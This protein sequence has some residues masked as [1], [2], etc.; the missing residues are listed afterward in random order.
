MSKVAFSARG[1]P[2]FPRVPPPREAK[3]MGMGR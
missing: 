3:T 1:N 2:W